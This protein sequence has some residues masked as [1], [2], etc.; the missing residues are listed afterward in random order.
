[1]NETL[2]F[3]QAVANRCGYRVIREK[4]NDASYSDWCALER[5]LI[6]VTV[7]TGVGLCPLDYEK[8]IPI[9]QDHYD[10]LPLTAFYFEQK[11]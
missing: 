5:D 9:W 8:L 4:N 2:E 3:T 1:M 10:L 6:A 7:E 11:Q